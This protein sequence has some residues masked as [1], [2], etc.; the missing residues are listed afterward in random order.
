MP[1][2]IKTVHWHPPADYELAVEVML[3]PELRRRGSEVHFRAP[4]RVEFYLLLAVT[5]GRTDHVVDFSPYAAEPGTWLLLRPGQMQRFDFSRPWDGL[6]LLFRP[7]FLPPSDTP[8]L[9]SSLN[10]VSSLLEALPSRIDLLPD[11][12]ELCCAGVTQMSRDAALAASAS[13]RNALLLHQLQALLWR[14]ALSRP[15][16][17]REPLWAPHASRVAALRRLVEVE[18]QARRTVAWYAAQLG[19][20]EKTLNRSTQAVVGTPAKVL[21]S[22][23]IVLEAKRLLVHTHLPVQAIAGAVGFDEA[24]NFVKFFK[25]EAG[26][27]PTRFRQRRGEP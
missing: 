27:T 26:C 2:H 4:Q 18:L 3:V 14:L 8:L 22:G 5:E 23:R 6:V 13:D 24:S 7:D 1:D 19:C 16:G 20:S 15:P 21:L 11:L 10:G 17:D 25:R 12:H 9:L